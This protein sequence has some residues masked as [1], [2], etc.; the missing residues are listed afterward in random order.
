M[1]NYNPYHG[2]GA[3][4]PP[5]PQ[6]PSSPR[7]PPGQS[8]G[9]LASWQAGT[10]LLGNLGHVQ[11]V[12]ELSGQITEALGTSRS[13]PTAD[14]IPVV[15]QVY[16]MT[17]GHGKNPTQLPRAWCTCELLQEGRSQQQFLV[18]R[19]RGLVTP[20]LQPRHDPGPTE[21]G[22]KFCPARPLCWLCARV[23]QW[24]GSS[25]VTILPPLPHEHHRSPE[26][27]V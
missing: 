2:P 18:A 23:P 21:G 16:L 25:Q 1:L 24:R 14:S 15:L 12:P 5:H 19:Q 20:A 3:G 26:V 27:Y 4:A 9:L 8:A 7:T 13:R 6:A 22:T 17:L 10:H 11:L